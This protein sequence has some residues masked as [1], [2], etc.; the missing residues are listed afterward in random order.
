MLRPGDELGRDDLKASA[1][2]AVE[3]VEPSGV[4][5]AAMLIEILDGAGRA[6]DF[7][8]LPGPGFSSFE[9]AGCAFDPAGASSPGRTSADSGSSAPCSIGRSPKIFSKL[10]KP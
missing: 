3:R 1:P 10:G 4:G 8:D 2:A 7:F 9:A 5:L 6:Q